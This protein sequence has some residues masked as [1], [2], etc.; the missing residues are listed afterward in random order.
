MTMPSP[1]MPSRQQ[2]E[3]PPV[4]ACVRVCPR[5]SAYVR[6]CPRMA[7]FR[8]RLPDQDCSVA[9][10]WC[11]GSGWRVVGVEG[12]G[13]VAGFTGDHHLVVASSWTLRAYDC[14]DHHPVILADAPAF[15]VA[16]RSLPSLLVP[17]GREAIALYRTGH[18]RD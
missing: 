16:V 15:F 3:C 8:S 9:A 5:M 7:A 17:G 12:S 1:A 2:P 6:V 13:A 10:C 14:V 18:L 11:I 4:S